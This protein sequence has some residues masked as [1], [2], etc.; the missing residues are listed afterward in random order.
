MCCKIAAVSST[1]VN[2]ALLTAASRQL[3]DAVDFYEWRKEVYILVH[4][5]R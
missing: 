3:H 5:W 4:S 2:V 1:V